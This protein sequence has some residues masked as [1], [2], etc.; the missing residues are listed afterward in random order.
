MLNH[1]G[2]RSAQS[3][4]IANKVVR[5]VMGRSPEGCQCADPVHRGATPLSKGEPR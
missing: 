4:G 3:T 5:Q 1:K 2:K